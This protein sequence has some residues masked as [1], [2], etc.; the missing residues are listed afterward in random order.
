MC[1]AD[2]ADV[3]L[4]RGLTAE[5]DHLALLQHAQQPRLQVERHVADLVEEQRAAVRLQDLAARALAAG[6]GE[7]ARLVPEQFAL[8]QRLG[9]RRAVDGDKGLVS[10]VARTVDRLREH[11]LAGA[12]LAQQYERDVTFEQLLRTL[13]VASHAHVAE[14]Q[15]VE[16]GR[17]GVAGDGRRAETDGT[18]RIRIAARRLDA[19]EVPPPLAAVVQR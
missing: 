14:L 9:D 6:A 11:V 5:R 1:G 10:A 13:D 2:Q 4:D 19:R 15:A 17:V 16:P 3:D 8:D 7:G 18:R 12:G